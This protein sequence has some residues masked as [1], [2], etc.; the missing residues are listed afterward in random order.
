[1]DGSVIFGT[2][3]RHGKLSFVSELQ[4]VDLA[5][6]SVRVVGRVS[7]VDFVRNRATI[8]HKGSSLMVDV[9]LLETLPFKTNVSHSRCSLMSPA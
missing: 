8:T 3:L 1:M 9:S 5:G 4:S 2:S 7:A 6:C